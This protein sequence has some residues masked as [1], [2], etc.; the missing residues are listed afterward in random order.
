MMKITNSE[1]QNKINDELK[2]TAD[3]FEEEE[4]DEYDED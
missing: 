3:L 2:K 1:L 4:E